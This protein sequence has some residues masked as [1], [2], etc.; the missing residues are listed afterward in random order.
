MSDDEGTTAVKY[1][2]Y[3]T[4]TSAATEAI[5]IPTTGTKRKKPPTASTDDDYKDPD[6]TPGDEATVK[7]LNV[8]QSI[9]RP[10]RRKTKVRSTETNNWVVPEDDDI[11]QFDEE[12]EESKQTTEHKTDE[13]K[14]EEKKEEFPTCNCELETEDGKPSDQKAPATLNTVKKE[15]PTQG[16]QF[17]GCSNPNWRERCKFFLWDSD[18]Q[19]GDYKTK[20]KAVLKPIDVKKTHR[21]KEVCLCGDKAVAKRSTTPS[22]PNRVFWSCPTR[23]C[24]FFRW[25]D[26]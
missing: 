1:K 18:F 19:S 24:Q 6:Y 3:K 11:T 20:Q 5:G 22:N 13:T 25:D 17:W 26:T 9:P 14:E 21:K 2:R 15:G 8:I 16:Q 23:K 10:K 7:E 12:G 4:T